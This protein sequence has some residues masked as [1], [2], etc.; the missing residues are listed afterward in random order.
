MAPTDPAIKGR[1]QQTQSHFPLCFG[2]PIQILKTSRPG[3][4]SWLCHLLLCDFRAITLKPQ[5][6]LWKMKLTV[7]PHV[8]N[9]KTILAATIII[10]TIFI[11]IIIISNSSKDLSGSDLLW[12]KNWPFTSYNSERKE[13]VR[14][15]AAKG[16]RGRKPRIL[17]SK[18]KLSSDLLFQRLLY[19]CRQQHPFT[20]RSDKT[21][22]PC[23]L[24]G[25][26]TVLWA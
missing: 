8:I 2:L 5:L 14:R 21:V 24:N 25:T 9:I 10:F 19:I 12:S 17:V 4:G 18:W 22:I 3:L 23:Y 11:F 26:L 7:N 1:G 13:T 16:R 6:P 20:Y 15:K